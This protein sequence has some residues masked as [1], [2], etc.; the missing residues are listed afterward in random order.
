MKKPAKSTQSSAAGHEKILTLTSAQNPQHPIFTLQTLTKRTYIV[1][2]AELVPAV[3]RNPQSL[4]LYPFITAMSPRMFGVPRGGNTMKIIEENLDGKEG[5][6]GL[7]PET[8]KGM[9]EAMAAGS[10]NLE[11]M[12]NVMLSSMK[13]FLDELSGA[14]QGA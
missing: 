4:S 10:A 8:T 14:E 11:R 12:T 13:G 9:H 6:K 5:I 3:D 2:S 1:T 7:I